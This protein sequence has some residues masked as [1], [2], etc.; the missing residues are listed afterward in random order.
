[1]ST[2]TAWYR[3][4]NPGG[5]QIGEPFPYSHVSNLWKKGQGKSQSI[6]IPVYQGSG[7][8]FHKVKI[9]QIS[10]FLFD[11]QIKYPFQDNRLTISKQ[12]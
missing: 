7:F 9:T 2:E 6:Y 3:G 8:S 1:M 12:I 11:K 5:L 4:E 10:I